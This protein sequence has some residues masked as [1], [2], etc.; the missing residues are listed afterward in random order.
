MNKIILIFRFN[1]SKFSHITVADALAARKD[2]LKLK[3]IS[4]SAPETRND[5][6]SLTKV[7]VGRV[8]DRGGRPAEM[9]TPPPEMPSWQQ[10]SGQSHASTNYNKNQRGGGGGGGE[11]FLHPVMFCFSIMQSQRRRYRVANSEQ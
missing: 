8:P 7:K 6:N 11:F 1:Q 3:K 2:L 5:K 9:A 10:R 4:S